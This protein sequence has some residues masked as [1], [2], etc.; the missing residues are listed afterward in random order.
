MTK[1]DKRLQK[2]TK[3]DKNITRSDKMLHNI[4]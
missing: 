4:A 1:D 3:D 2:M